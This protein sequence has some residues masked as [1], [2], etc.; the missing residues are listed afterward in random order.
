MT[1]IRDIAHEQISASTDAELQDRLAVLTGRM[2][3]SWNH[4]LPQDL[5]SEY[6]KIQSE[7]FCR[8]NNIVSKPWVT[9][10]VPV[11]RYAY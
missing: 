8:A 7:L 5:L 2:D 1:E 6:H 3:R 10:G 9:Y 4:T 11:R